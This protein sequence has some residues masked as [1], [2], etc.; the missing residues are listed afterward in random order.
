[1]NVM[2]IT[3]PIICTIYYSFTIVGD[4]LFI[5]KDYIDNLILS[6]FDHINSTVVI[7]VI[8]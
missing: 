8:V 6:I 4:L 2:Y 5:F 3:I 1:M 7:L